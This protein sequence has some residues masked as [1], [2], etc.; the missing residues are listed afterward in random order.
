MSHSLFQY[1]LRTIDIKPQYIPIKAIP[2][3][4]D[5]KISNPFHP[6]QT[7]PSTQQNNSSKVPYSSPPYHL[8]DM[9]FPIGCRLNQFRNAWQQLGAWE[10]VKIGIQADWIPSESIGYLERNRRIPDQTR[11]LQSKNQLEILAQVM[12][13]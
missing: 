8:I 5:Y 2:L 10:I 3:L 7:I 6:L 4:Q 11:A 12:Q 13:M 9:K 1:N